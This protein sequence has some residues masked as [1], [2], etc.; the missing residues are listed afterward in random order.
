MKENENVEVIVLEAGADGGFIQ[1]YPE[2]TLQDMQDIVGG[3]IEF[4]YLGD[5]VMVVNEEGLLL[6]KPYNHLANEFIKTKSP[7]MSEHTFIVGDVF[8]IKNKDLK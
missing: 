4:I 5:D 1:N 7:Q 6:N 3:F 2:I 8:I